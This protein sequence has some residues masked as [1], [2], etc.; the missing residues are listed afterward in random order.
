MNWSGLL[1][2]KMPGA[3]RVVSDP[4]RLK[5]LAKDGFSIVKGKKKFSEVQ[6]EITTLITMVTDSVR[7]SY[8]GLGK[9]NLLMIVAG[10][11]YLVN[12]LDI[13]PDFI[14][15][16]GFADDLSVLVYIISKLSE[17]MAKYRFWKKGEVE[18]EEAPDLEGYTVIEDEK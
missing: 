6:N 14:F 4:D 3:S 2:R 13:V 7:G 5:K 9:K 10:L 15:G 17:E 8:K 12:P 18:T 16:I 11:I 1:Q